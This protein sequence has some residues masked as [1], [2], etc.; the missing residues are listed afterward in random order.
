MFL[1]HSVRQ[2]KFNQVDVSLSDKSEPRPNFLSQ[3]RDLD[4]AVDWRRGQPN[5]QAVVLA[6]RYK[7]LAEI[8][9]LHPTDL[10]EV[11]GILA[12]QTLR[13]LEAIAAFGRLYEN[14]Q[15]RQAKA[16]ARLQ[17][18][19]N[20]WRNV[21]SG[22]EGKAGKE[23]VSVLDRKT[24]TLL[25]N[26]ARRNPAEV[27]IISSLAS[28]IRF[29][30]GMPDA[31]Q[32]LKM[33]SNKPGSSELVRICLQFA[34]E[35]IQRQATSQALRSALD[36]PGYCLE[37][38]QDF[39]IFH[40]NRS[41]CFEHFAWNCSRQSS[42]GSDEMR[43]LL[44]K[45]HRPEDVPASVDDLMQHVASLPPDEA[46]G[47][48]ILATNGLR[49]W[50]S[51]APLVETVRTRVIDCLMTMLGGPGLSG[52]F[53]SKAVAALMLRLRQFTPYWNNASF[54]ARA[55]SLILTVL[56]HLAS[57]PRH[58]YTALIAYGRG[59]H[60][61]AAEAF[62]LATDARPANH[63]ANSSGF[64]S[65]LDHRNVAGITCLYDGHRQILGQ[66]SL[67][68]IG[69]R[70][71]ADQR[72]VAITTAD[73]KYFRRYSVQYAKSLGQKYKHGKIHFHLIGKIE[74]VASIVSEIKECLAGHDVSFS[75]ENA[76]NSGPIYFATARILRLRDFLS[77]FRCS[78][79]LVDI[80]NLWGESPNDFFCRLEESTDIA[81]WVSNAVRYSNS[82]R[83]ELTLRYPSLRPWE[84]TNAQ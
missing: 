79:F 41:I 52:P 21:R 17:R 11:E 75:D 76:G 34:G 5:N 3:V 20:D 66:D 56:P 12:E 40:F 2:T 50:D 58:L 63:P 43:S 27:R 47:T 31:I 7:K 83:H 14:D 73:E 32:M 38:N 84:I 36:V 54:R 70:P 60:D 28:V 62:R 8:S 49:L 77:W 78:V 68:F 80:D 65:F 1:Q 67:R 35:Q 71:P 23:A 59:E 4:R 48:L 29:S 81:L 37:C 64:V 53:A 19:T 30:R 33:A 24:E 51:P 61:R 10:N 44:K 82:Q 22:V 69:K 45:Y 57:L 6:D 9:A 46:M 18:I 72:P 13:P 25:Q 42:F 26:L 55:D 16:L 39:I 15:K 74:A